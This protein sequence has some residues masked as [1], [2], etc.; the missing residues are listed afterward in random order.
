ML[1]SKKN[2]INLP[3][4]GVAR[5]LI[6]YTILFSSI[7]TLVI[8][9]FNLY[10]RYE[11]DIG[12][13]DSHFKQIEAVHLSSLN[14][15]LWLADKAELQVH[16]DGIKQIPDIQYLEVYDNEKI[17]A[18]AGIKKNED[19]KTRILPL[20]YT[21]KNKVI[22]IGHLRIDASLE[23]VYHNIYNELG[24]TLATNGI[25]TFL[26]AF[27]ML[28][29]FQKLVVRHLHKIAAEVT[30][31]DITRPNKKIRLER[32]ENSPAN[33]DEFDLVVDAFDK[34]QN[35]L[36]QSFSSIEEKVQQRTRE[37]VEAR[38]EAI[39]ASSA[40][41]EFLSRMSHELRTPM[42]A[43]LGFAQILEM[44]ESLNPSQKEYIGE[45]LNAGE[46][47]LVLINEVL[48][49]SRIESGQIVLDLEPVSISHIVNEAVALVKP[50][51]TQYNV[52]LNWDSNNKTQWSVIAEKFRL[53]QILLNLLSNAIKY[54]I[55]GGQITI[56]MERHDNHKLR[57]NIIDTGPGLSAGQ[58][59][60][61]FEPFNRAGAESSVIEGT[62][63]GLTISMRLIEL[64][65]GNIGVDSKIG[66]GS[67]FYIDLDL[68][69]KNDNIK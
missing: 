44:D 1:A 21:Y 43:V 48:D 11:Y 35:N 66:K 33:K 40:K 5:K 50:L 3:Y 55:S 20:V 49:L 16:L 7:I 2:I 41:T 27:F 9:A 12:L 37:L 54:N 4:K 8:T 65:K 68:A 45:I 62:G 46:H 28:F 14:N 25:K 34:L 24:I 39:N 56:Q 51:L 53:K 13:I 19:I 30:L 57:I 67:C 26:V 23:K 32:K 69:E 29:L 61:I 52:T 64:M 63:I 17:W 42:N 18:S 6:S 22:N 60:K 36:R 59:L 10:S 58:Q 38:T 15:N 31:F 47:L